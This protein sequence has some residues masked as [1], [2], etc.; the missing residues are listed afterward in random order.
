[1]SENVEKSL[2][3]MRQPRLT[4][5]FFRSTLDSVKAVMALLDVV[6]P[7]VPF[8][9]IAGSCAAPRHEAPKP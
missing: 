6:R 4:S 2:G 7:R 1:M 9:P 8:D 3:W 5:P